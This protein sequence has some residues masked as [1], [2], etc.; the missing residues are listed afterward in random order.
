MTEFWGEQGYYFVRETKAERNPLVGHP[1]LTP[2]ST[3]NLLS[4][5]KESIV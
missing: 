5:R 4:S 1:L 3:L 2:T